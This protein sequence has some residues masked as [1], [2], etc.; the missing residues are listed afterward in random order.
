MKKIIFF[1]LLSFF[2]FSFLQAA[3][4][5]FFSQ[6]LLR[7]KIKVKTLSIRDLTYHSATVFG[8]ISGTN[9][10][11]LSR[12][13]CYSKDQ[14]APIE[15]WSKV[16]ANGS[17]PGLYHA[18]LSKLEQETMYYIRGFVKGPD[19]FYYG[20]Q[21]QFKTLQGE[22]PAL[23]TLEVLKVFT[24]WAAVTT[25]I[26]EDGGHKIQERGIVW[27][28][29]P[30][31][32]MQNWN[33]IVDSTADYGPYVTSILGL[34]P[35]NKYYVRSYAINQKGTK[36]GN[37]LEFQTLNGYP[38]LLYTKSADSIT[39][40]SAVLRGE[41]KEYG[42]SH[43]IRGF[44]WS[45]SDSLEIDQWT[46]VWAPGIYNETDGV[47]GSFSL[48]LNNLLPNTTYYFRAFAVNYKDYVF[49]EMFTFKTHPANR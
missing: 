12:G 36:Y 34:K 37:I 47:S 3:E 7:I 39:S 8:K 1:S 4:N 44:Y 14:N 5:R 24:D 6:E 29:Y 20:K 49:G 31:Q 11:G 32:P 26:Y 10:G 33:K 41:I 48:T 9:S 23:Q 2:T 22:L 38:P 46:R 19:Q 21:S 30:R 45:T 17:G 42:L 28:D 18:K 15:Q 35:K 27:T 16:Y 25:N 40:I 43:V 13:F